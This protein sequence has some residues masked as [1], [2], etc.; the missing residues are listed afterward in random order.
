MTAWIV[1][2][3]CLLAGWFAGQYRLPQ[4]GFEWLYDRAATTTEP[5]TI[6]RFVAVSIALV[7]FVVAWIVHPARSRRA[8]CKL[9]ERDR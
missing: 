6:R 5:R 8:V 7:L 9:R 1:A 4:R 3:A 2:I